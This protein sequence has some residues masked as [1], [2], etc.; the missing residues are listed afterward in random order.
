MSDMRS[1][2]GSPRFAEHNLVA[3]YATAEQA[4][5]ALQ[6]LERKGVEAGDIEL[7]GP[8]IAAAQQPQTNDEQREVDLAV[9][10]NVGKRLGVGIFAG[11]IIGAIVGALLG[12]LIGDNA[13]AIA[14]GGF[15]GAAAGVALGFFYGGYSGLPVNEQ[16]G[17][18]FQG[19]GGETSVAVH[20]DDEGHIKTAL[21]AL[22]GSDARRLATCGR[23]GQLRDVA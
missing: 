22:K 3:T 11:A 9:T 6:M 8:G 21:E 10:T 13:V 2:A 15:A 23:D 12:M 18:T 14:M 16:F 5:A 19:D 17:E 1:S 4:R 20:S 7:F